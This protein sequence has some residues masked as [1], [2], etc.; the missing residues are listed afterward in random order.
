MLYLRAWRA[1]ADLT[2]KEVGKAVGRH[3][4]AVAKWEDG[5]VSPTARE[6]EALAASYGVHPGAL[7]IHPGEWKKE[8]E[9]GSLEIL[10][11]AIGVPAVA[12]LLADHDYSLARELSDCLKI[13]QRASAEF[14]KLWLAMGKLGASIS[15]EPHS[16]QGEV[17]SEK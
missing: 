2:L 10:A 17:S 11:K 14:K 4:S 9:I 1:R 13:L 8:A 5:S 6:L 16:E 7:F 12:L 15:E 3:L